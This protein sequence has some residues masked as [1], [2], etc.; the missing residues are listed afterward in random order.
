MLTHG[1]TVVV[2]P[3][4]D[5][6]DVADYLGFLDRHAIHTAYIPPSFLPDLRA[7]GQPTPRS[8]AS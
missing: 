2:V 8:A 6:L 1:G 5:R 3:E 4:E 7:R